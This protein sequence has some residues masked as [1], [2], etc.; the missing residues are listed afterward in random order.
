MTSLPYS[1]KSE[2]GILVE[3]V[4]PE[5]G[6][7]RLEARTRYFARLID[8][9]DSALSKH[10]QVVVSTSTRLGRIKASTPV[11]VACDRPLRNKA[12]KGKALEDKFSRNLGKMFN[13]K[14]L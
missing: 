6:A 4:Y 3:S 14:C 11:C 10:D 2:M 9:T 13:E 5:P 8:A 12:R 1:L 7:L